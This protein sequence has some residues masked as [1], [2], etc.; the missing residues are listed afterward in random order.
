MWDGMYMRVKGDFFRKFRD[1]LHSFTYNFKSHYFQNTQNYLAPCFALD[2]RFE[3]V[4][5][6]S[7]GQACADF[8]HHDT[9]S[10]HNKPHWGSNRF[11]TTPLPTKIILV[12]YLIPKPCVANSLE[13]AGLESKGWAIIDDMTTILPTLTS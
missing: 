2:I 11:G 12:Y 9:Q 5:A 6:L 8:P 7:H 3:S 4:V 13:R 10:V 1:Q